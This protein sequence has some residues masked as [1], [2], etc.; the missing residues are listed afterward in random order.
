LRAKDTG[1]R[2]SPGRRD[3]GIATRERKRGDASVLA[4]SCAQVMACIHGEVRMN[5]PLNDLFEQADRQ[6]AALEAENDEKQ[7][8]S[9]PSE[10]IDKETAARFNQMDR[11]AASHRLRMALAALTM[12]VFLASSLYVKIR[13]PRPTGP[14]HRVM[15]VVQSSVIVWSSSL[16]WGSVAEERVALP[17]GRIV[18]IRSDSGILLKSGTPL[19]IRLYDTGAAVSERPL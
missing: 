12:L 1:S 10:E 3:G 13:M 7:S 6:L 5:K 19:A 2:P 11:N 9:V 14:Y 4:F 8:S 17:D 15:G 16:H 18:R